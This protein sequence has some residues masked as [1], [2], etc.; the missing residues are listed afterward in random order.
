MAEKIT[1]ACAGCGRTQQLRP[2]K[3]LNCDYY[4]C[5]TSS[6]CK[7]NPDWK[8]PAR[9]EGFIMRI[10]MNAAGAFTGYQIM[11]ATE[12]ELAAIARARAI[13]DE[14]VRQALERN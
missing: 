1:I 12:E 11:P 7:A 8:H 9:P 10:H 3:L 13:R 6:P 5:G 2:S 14:G 4:T